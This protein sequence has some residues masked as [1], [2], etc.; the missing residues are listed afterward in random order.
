MKT[1]LTVSLKTLLT[2]RSLNICTTSRTHQGTTAGINH[3]RPI[4]SVITTGRRLRTN[5]EHIHKGRINPTNLVD[6]CRQTD[7]R[8]NVICV[9]LNAR[10]ICNKDVTVKEHLL[11]HGGDFMFLTET[12]C[13]LNKTAVV[14]ELTPPDYSYIGECRSAKRGGGVGILYKSEYKLRKTTT[15]RYETFEHLDVTSTQ[16]FE[17]YAC[18]RHL[19]S[20]DN[21]CTAVP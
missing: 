12:W 21:K 7:T 6:I 3:F 4:S 20:T 8:Y 2:L 16:T 1:N 14:N 13:K 15:K 18:C 17:N 5:I 11:N 10:S 19:S 9:L